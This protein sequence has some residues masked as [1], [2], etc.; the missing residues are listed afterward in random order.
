MSRPVAIVV[1]AVLVLAAGLVHG[2]LTSRWQ[3]SYALEEAAA[4][5][6]RVPLEVGDWKGTEQAVDADM[7]ARAGAVAYWSRRYENR[8]TGAVV[9]VILMCGRAGKMAVHTPDVCYRG[10]GYE[11]TGAMRRHAIPVGDRQ[12]EFWTGDFNKEGSL[13]A[14]GLRLFWSWSADG[15]WQAPD[16]PRFTF[17][18]QPALYKLYAV[19]DIASGAEPLETD[20][21]AALLRQLLPV[22]EEA[23]FPPPP[24]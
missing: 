14:Q 2:L 1:A 10:A 17:R 4:R 13:L 20:P 16:S 24:H 22:M 18:G 3:T 7:F 11:M 19:R 9:T 15:S 21:T 12:A 23:L 8:K 5:V 6:P